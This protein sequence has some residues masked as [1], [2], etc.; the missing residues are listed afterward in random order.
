MD[1]TLGPAKWDLVNNFVD[2]VH[3]RATT[4]YDALRGIADWLKRFS[5]AGLTLRLDKCNWLREKITALGFIASSQGLQADPAKV[6]A[7]ADWKQPKYVGDLWSFTGL[8]GFFAQFIKNH[9]EI[10][11]PLQDAIHEG[12]AAYRAAKEVKT[13]K[14]A[15][16]AKQESIS[17]GPIAS[18]NS[19]SS[20]RGIVE[21]G[22]HHKDPFLHA[23]ADRIDPFCVG[24]LLLKKTDRAMKRFLATHP[25]AWN[26]E[27]IAAFEAAKTAL[28]TAPV[29]AA[30]RKGFP[31][32]I[33]S[34]AVV[35]GGRT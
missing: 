9:A 2:D 4:A 12:V 27:R 17:D 8:L 22:S 11:R 20:L 29:L 28:T 34:D 25:V 31:M 18:S 16:K 1:D 15:P 19:T 7:I 3:T 21:I 33:H 13:A 35:G 26:A 5:E 23:N 32:T 30:P 10:V 24:R 14:A 6:T